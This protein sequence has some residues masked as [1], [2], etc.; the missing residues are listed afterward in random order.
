MF[1]CLGVGKNLWCV[2]MHFFPNTQGAFYRKT[3]LFFPKMSLWE[4]L[5]QEFSH[6]TAS[7][8]YGAVAAV[9]ALGVIVGVCVLGVA[10]CVA[11]RV[12]APREERRP[13]LAL[14]I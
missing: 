11:R 6:A 14:K 2:H 7:Q 3:I 1:G 12:F 13:L 10:V 9:T 8:A 4:G 5:F